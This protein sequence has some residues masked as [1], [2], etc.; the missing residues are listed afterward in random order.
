MDEYITIYHSIDVVENIAK[1]LV[2]KGIKDAI[3]LDNGGSVGLYA[4]W[5][6]NNAGGWL[7]TC[8][9]FRFERISYIG[10]ILK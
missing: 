10:L 4:S 7:N 5:L 3:I 9:Y 2:D 6:N 1:K 8:S